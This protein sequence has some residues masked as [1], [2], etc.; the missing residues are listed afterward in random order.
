M[1]DPRAVFNDVHKH[2]GHLTATNDVEVEDQ[3]FDRKE[4]ARPGPDSPLS[5][6]LRHE[7][8]VRAVRL[9]GLGARP[10]CS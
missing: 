1:L 7:A 4:A 10:C 5:A 2:L 3:F 8:M 9:G 6:T